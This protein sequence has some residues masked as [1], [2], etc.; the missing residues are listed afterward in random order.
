MR[1]AGFAITLLL[2]TT[3]SSFA[4]TNVTIIGTKHDGNQHFDHKTIYK[5]LQDIKPDVILIEQDDEYKKV[6]ALTIAKEVGF[7]IAIEDLAVQK[8]KKKNKDCIIQPYDTSFDRKK[9][10]QSLIQNYK[11]INSSLKQAYKS[12][13]MTTAD[14]EN[15][16]RYNQLSNFIYGKALNTTLEDMNSNDVLDSCRV[17]Y[18]LDR[19]SHKDAVLQYVADT[20]VSNWYQGELKFWDDRNN[21]MASRILHHIN[22]YPGKNIVVLSGL[23]HKYYLLDALAPY[24]KKY[25]FQIV[26]FP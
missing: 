26:S 2:F 3:F 12:E 7:K 5:Y 20:S 4:Q 11:Q 24:E 9:Y 15:Y 23:L 10:V 17:L 18:H 16:L 8:Y 22:Q 14:R 19:S 6:T 13:K 21:Y 25:G 1:K